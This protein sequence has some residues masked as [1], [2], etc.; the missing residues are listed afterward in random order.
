MTYIEYP[1]KLSFTSQVVIRGVVAAANGAPVSPNNQIKFGGG[2]E[3]YGVET[4][5]DNSDFPPE[6][7]KLKGSVLLAPG[8]LITLSGSSGAIGGTMVGDSFNLAGG[9]GGVVHGNLI[10]LGTAP[11]TITGGGSIARTKSD[12]I[13]AGV[14]FNRTFQS[15]PKTYTEVHP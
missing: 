13:P 12:E 15:V 6:M 1:N 3:A 10:G 14:I 5:P 4:L 2:I 8:F 7:R 9:S 11:F